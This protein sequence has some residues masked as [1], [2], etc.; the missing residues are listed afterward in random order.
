MQEF[1]KSEELVGTLV[2]G[3]TTL[4]MVETVFKSSFIVFRVINDKIFRRLSFFP[5]L[6]VFIGERPVQMINRQMREQPALLIKVN[7][8]D[9]SIKLRP[10][11]EPVKF[12][13]TRFRV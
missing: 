1:K 11:L 3:L 13:T 12:F 2:T 7:G 9:K 8:S 4:G 10:R 5:F 6:S